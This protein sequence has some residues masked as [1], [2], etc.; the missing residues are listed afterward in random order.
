MGNR[1]MRWCCHRRD[2]C[3]ILWVS[4][5]GAPAEPLLEDDMSRHDRLTALAQSLSTSAQHY[6]AKGDT[7]RHEACHEDLNCVLDMLDQEQA[8]QPE[9]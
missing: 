9:R 6:A 3:A 5:Q 4:G 2:S 8:E 7:R 1:A